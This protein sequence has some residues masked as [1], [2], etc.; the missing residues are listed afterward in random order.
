MNATIFGPEGPEITAWERDFFRE[1]QPLGFIVFAR[2]IDTP[3]QLRRLTADLRTAVGRNAPILIDQEGGRVQRMRSPHWRDY[4][5]ALDQMDRARDPLRAQ[6]IRNRL[7]AA[8][9]H[10]VGIDVNCA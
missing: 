3:E 8:E 5:P 2:N 7:I 10:D 4:L 1:T 6:W 9:L